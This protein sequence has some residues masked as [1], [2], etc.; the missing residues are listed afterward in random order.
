MRLESPG[1][2]FVKEV[3][4]KKFDEEVALSFGFDG[5]SVREECRNFRANLSAQRRRLQT[6]ITRKG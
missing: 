2:N 5:G 1:V 6:S 4:G 3:A